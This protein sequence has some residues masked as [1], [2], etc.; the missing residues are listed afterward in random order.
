[1]KP[2][3]LIAFAMALLICLCGL[4]A[5]ATE[6]ETEETTPDTTVAAV[7]ESTTASLYDEEGYLLDSLPDS[8]DFNKTEIWMLYDELVTMPEY[9]VESEN[10]EL[11]NDAIWKRNIT[12]ED[13]LN[14]V[15][16]FYGTQ[17]NDTKQTIYCTAAQT[18]YDSGDN[19][20][21]LYGAYSRTIPLL[22]MK[23]FLQDLCQTDYFM[24]ENPWWPD[25]LT[26]ELTIKDKL[27]MATGDISTTVLWMMSTIYYNKVLWTEA[28]T[29]YELEDLVNS[30]DWTLDK[31]IEIIK[32]FYRDDGDGIV[33]DNDIFGYTFFNACVDAFLNYAGVVSIDKDENG[34]LKL[35]DDFLGEKTDNIVSKLGAVC[36]T[37]TFHYSSDESVERQ[38][39]YNGHALFICDGSY[40]VTSAQ[41]NNGIEFEY[42]ILPGPKYDKEQPKYVTNMRYPYEMYAINSGSTYVKEAS[43]VLEAQGSAG[44]R[45][46]TPAI[47]EVTMKARYASDNESSKMYDL[48]REGVVFDIGRIYN[49]SINNFYPNFRNTCF[50]GGRGWIKSISGINKAVKLQLENVMK[51]YDAD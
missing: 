24:A 25:S 1:M 29:G 50:S 12:V 45:Y 23:G 15:L 46:V 9:F 22:S 16:K 30:G 34:N 17:G 8:L 6:P 35:S 37:K 21:A 40:V 10:G 7:E 39:F 41:S 31:F 28:A 3:R 11:V 5:C 33:N 36:T 47:F 42:G 18:D 51:L 20:Y 27:F 13:R 38:V 19:K 49:Y 32:D 43:A 14:C 48:I 44:Y 4:A 2:K 26:N